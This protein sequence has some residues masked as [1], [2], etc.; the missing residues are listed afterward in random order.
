MKVFNRKN[1]LLFLFIT[2]LILSFQINAQ[3]KENKPVK[4]AC[5]GNSI[6][7]GAGISNREKNAYPVQLQNILGDGYKVGNFGHS[8]RTL[9]KKGDYP[10][11]N[12]ELYKKAL[13]FN[14]DIV[15]IM[16]GTNDS[17]LQNRVHLNE[18]K[19]DYTE[20]INSFKKKNNKV[21]IVILLPIPSFLEDTSSIWDP[22]IKDRIIPKL[23][24][25]AYDTHSEVIDLYQLFIDK[26]QLLSDKIHPTSLGATLI[27]NRIY[28]DIKA[29][30]SG[31]FNIM[32]KIKVDSVKTSDFHG[33]QQYN[34]KYKGNLCRI[35]SPKKVAE[36]KP[37]V[38]RARFWGH[39]PQ[40]DIALLERGFHIAF[41]DI[42]DLYGAPEA[43]KRWNKFYKLM[44]KAGLSEKVGIEGMRRG[45]LIIY[46]WAVKNPKKVACIYA[47]APVLDGKSW[48]GGFG[49]SKG[50]T[51]GWTEF[52]KVYHLNTE[53]KVVGFKGDPI[54]KTKKI[55]KG[56]YPMMHVCGEADKVVPV[57]ENTRIFEKE[58]KAY[59]GNISVIYKKGVDHHP[60][61]LKNP[62]RIVNFILRNTG[63]MFNFAA[64]PAPGSE[65]R[66][67]AGWKKGK[68]WWAQMYDID[69]LC[70]NSGKTDL[71]IIGNSITQ[72]WGGSRTLTTYGPGQKAADKYFKDLKWINAGI[73]GDRTQHV[74]WRIINGHYNACDPDTVVLAIGVNN[75]NDNTAD[76]IIKGIELDLN[77]IKNKIP[78]AKIL[79]YGPLP[80]GTKAGSER[81]KKYN[82]IHKAIKEK[83]S[84]PRINYISLLQ[85]M[86]L[87]NG[88]LNPDYY[89]SD[90]IHLIPAGYYIWAG[91]ISKFIKE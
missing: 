54:H 20:L 52:K 60:H 28:E 86:T 80:T 30:Y 57:D 50:N 53:K 58:I 6:T 21:K 67:A 18:F 51:N 88:D 27:A 39:E 49:K 17:K 59:G 82:D 76:E 29:S 12:S 64:I 89:S 61:S 84:D 33:F 77:L 45:G 15:Y 63:Y 23:E 79:L 22:V 16:L 3:V 4:I 7:F 1:N 74:A 37:W 35:V 34:F 40:T 46:N 11:W 66:S 69:S 8:G 83:E 2:L 41:C 55:S 31:N 9:L 48:P 65:Y 70:M 47:D 87:K 81:R 36:G 73:S 14:P 71:L 44:K 5:V 19:I 75:F 68:G 72:G 10:Y 32:D 25:V 42:A 13:Q 24:K 62:T 78:R 90:G 56:K 85:T 43:V 91:S 38:I 26:P